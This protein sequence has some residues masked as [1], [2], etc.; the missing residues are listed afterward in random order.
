MRDRFGYV[1][2]LDFMKIK[3]WGDCGAD[4]RSVG[5]EIE[6]EAADRLLKVEGTPRIANRLL[7]R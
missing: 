6:S 5:G 7:S 2:Q 3:I 4:G 1:Q